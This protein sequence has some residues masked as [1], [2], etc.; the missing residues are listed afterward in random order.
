MKWFKLIKHLF[1]LVQLCL[2]TIQTY[3]SENDFHLSE[4]IGNKEKEENK[5][6]DP[7]E[8]KIDNK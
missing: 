5:K 8:K 7:E 2:Q 3:C 4:Y 6:E 1:S